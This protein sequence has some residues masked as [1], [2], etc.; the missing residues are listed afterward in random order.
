MLHHM[1]IGLK[2]QQLTTVARGGS[3]LQ[4]HVHGDGKSE[5]FSHF[6][7]TNVCSLKN[8]SKYI[9]PNG[10]KGYLML[11][12]YNSRL[13]NSDDGFKNLSFMRLLEQVQKLLTTG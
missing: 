13:S 8:S 12:R 4:L 9:D 6:M 11:A 2:R 3:D 10:Q 5:W 7:I 1:N